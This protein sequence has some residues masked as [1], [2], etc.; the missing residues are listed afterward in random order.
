[1]SIEFKK[2]SP[3][4]ELDAFALLE[5]QKLP[6]S[7]IG[8]HV[9]LFALEKNGKMIATAGLEQYDKVGL[10][11]SVSVLEAEKS[12]GY[13]VLI[14]N[15]LEKYAKNNGIEELYLLTQNAKD[16]F[17]NKCQYAV[18]ERAKVANEIQNSPQFTSTCPSSAV[19]MKKVL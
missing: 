19:V 6:T 17:E 13:G 2:I 11:R 18:V 16:F 8:N 3:E 12:K 5:S 14:A 15:H 9:A 7:D 4:Q 1:M 10:L